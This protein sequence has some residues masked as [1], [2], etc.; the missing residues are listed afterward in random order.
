MFSE[1]LKSY[2]FEGVVFD[3]LVLNYQD[4]VRLREVSMMGKLFPL[5]I[6]DVPKYISVLWDLSA[7][8]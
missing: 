3:V 8:M 4:V 6:V 5:L 2:D 7:L 1:W